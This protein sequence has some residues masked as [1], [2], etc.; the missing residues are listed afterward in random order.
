MPWQLE[1]SINVGD[2][3]PDAPGGQYTHVRVTL[4]GNDPD[5][6]SI[7]VAIHYGWLNEG[8]F[9]SGSLSPTNRKTS[10]LIRGDDWSS[11]V[12]NTVPDVV[13]TEPGHSSRY[14]EFTFDGS[15]AWR[16]TIYWGAKR[17]LYEELHTKGI[18]D[19]GTV[20]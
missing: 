11:I 15:P 13:S 9:V 2:M 10:Y 18:I 6:K 8:N 16:E 1:T 7:P 4:Q 17:G 5:E 19:D 14:Q 12:A 3:D 20:V